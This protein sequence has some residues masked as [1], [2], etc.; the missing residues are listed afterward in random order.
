MPDIRQMVLA[1]VYWSMDVMEN[2]RKG[3]LRIRRLKGTV[4]CRLGCYR[5]AGGVSIRF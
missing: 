5:K 4:R 3:V 2:D 1:A